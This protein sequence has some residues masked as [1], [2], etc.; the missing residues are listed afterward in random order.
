M[1]K[2]P[3]TWNGTTLSQVHLDKVCDDVHRDLWSIIK[4]EIDEINKFA[5]ATDLDVVAHEEFGKARGGGRLFQ[6][7][8][9]LLT[10]IETY[11]NRSEANRPLVI[12]GPSGSGKSS[13]MARSAI[14]ATKNFSIV[15]QRFIGATPR[16]V[17]GRSLLQSL[18][19]ELG[20]RFREDTAVPLEYRELVTAFRERVAWAT[21]DRPVIVFLD[22]LDQLSETDNAKSLVWLP[23]QLPPYV[24]IIVSVL[25]DPFAALPAVETK[26][27]TISDPLAVLKRRATPEDLL[28]LEDYPKEDAKALLE[29][30]LQADERTLTSDQSEVILKAFEKCP[31]P[32]FL[33]LAT[34]EA[35]H[36]RSGGSVPTMPSADSPDAM[37]TAIIEWLF[38]RLSEPS[39]HGQILVDR[40]IGYLVAAKNGLTEDELLGLLS[41]DAEFFDAFL[42]RAKNVGQ[43]LP[44]GV[45][46]LPVSVWVRLYSD[47]RSY[48]TTRQAD[49][50]TLLAFFHRS[51]EKAARKR[52]LG[53]SAIAGQRHKHIANYFTPKSKDENGELKL[54]PRGFFRLTLDEQRAW[55][56]KLPPRPRPVNLRMVVELPYQLIAE[57]KLGQEASKHQL[58]LWN[59]IVELLT[60]WRFLEAKTEAGLFSALI[61]EFDDL[62]LNLP[63][64]DTSLRELSLLHRTFRREASFLSRHPTFL[65][66]QTWNLCWWYDHPERATHYDIDKRVGS[67]KLPWEGEEAVLH[68]FMEKW[69]Q[70]KEYEQEG[71]WWLRS[72]LPPIEPI[73]SH[74]HDILQ[75]SD[76][77]DSISWSMNGLYIAIGS[78]VGTIRIWNA[79]LQREEYRFTVGEGGNIKVAWSPNNQLLAWGIEHDSGPQCEDTVGVWDVENQ[80]DRWRSQYM[81]VNGLAWAPDGK[82]LYLNTQHDGGKIVD[83]LSGKLMHAIE[84]IGRSAFALSPDGKEIAYA[85]YS[86]AIQV[87]RITVKL[88]IIR[89]RFDSPLDGGPVE[90]I[91]WSPDGQSL[92]ICADRVLILNSNNGKVKGHWKGQQKWIT[93]AI[94]SP[95]GRYLATHTG[96]ED[97]TLRIWDSATGSEQCKLR[98]HEWK[99]KSIAWSPDGRFLAS[100]SGNTLRIWEPQFGEELLTQTN[101]LEG[102]IGRSAS[103]S[104][105]GRLLATWQ[106]F[107][108]SRPKENYLQIWNAESGKV[109]FRLQGHDREVTCAAWSPSKHILASGASDNT[110][111]LWDAETG[112]EISCLVGHTTS[113]YCIS[114]S[115][116]GEMIASGSDSNVRIWNTVTGKLIHTLSGHLSG[117]TCAAW[118]MDGQFLASGSHDNTVR[119]WD[120]QTSAEIHCFDGVKQR[121]KASTSSTSGDI[122]KIAWSSDRQHVVVWS[123]EQSVRVWNIANGEC[124]E[125]YYGDRPNS[126]SLGWKFFAVLSRYKTS[127]TDSRLIIE[128]DLDAVVKLNGTPVAF[129]NQSLLHTGGSWA[130]RR[131]GGLVGRNVVFYAVEGSEWGFC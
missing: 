56:K 46:S 78:R 25:D 2:Y 69:R 24:K 17:D 74:L 66:Q 59:T 103:W 127:V 5:I 128:N 75:L 19:E 73:D 70:E 29:Y 39:K 89:P 100:S 31:R 98:G 121:S 129:L 86:N 64:G 83:S 50:T 109:V 35:K 23:R 79:I 58:N 123:S 122:Y 91:S 119:V 90:S 82:W 42:E 125:E 52:F 67:G 68:V 88:R 101:Q 80:E 81:P 16:S 96:Y 63:A 61:A 85:H 54:D 36:W 111:R 27:P 21:A 110:L 55:A 26:L 114:W 9:D 14:D 99:I 108:N 118:S 126:D 43:P 57:A 3:A 94:W 8:G 37:L 10:K 41:T 84:G 112:Q 97:L 116:N 49:G 77:I 40:A 102:L 28:P 65:F 38:N 124:E 51:L 47:L 87:R 13:L 107:H 22:A 11:L 53:T 93:K 6:G 95:N 34:E 115:P 130:G 44:P 71:F 12:T 106:E 120:A 92:A 76:V 62:V 32:L 117:V 1:R 113:V 48:L 15:I 131:V 60:T 7:R 18:C 45:E 72:L 4:A 20:R 104:Q 105:D 33:K 30:W